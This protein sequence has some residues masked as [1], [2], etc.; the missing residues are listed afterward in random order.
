MF[1][2]NPRLISQQGGG[3]GG[4]GWQEQEYLKYVSE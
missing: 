4:G 3:G 2:G 1:W